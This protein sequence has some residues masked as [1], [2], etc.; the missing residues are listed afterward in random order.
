MFMPVVLVEPEPEGFFDI[1]M[2]EP[3]EV[4][5]DPPGELK[6]DDCAATVAWLLVMPAKVAAVAVG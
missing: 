2:L 1:D 6:G 3:P 5:V 4:D